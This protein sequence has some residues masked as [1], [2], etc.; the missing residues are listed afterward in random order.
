MK[1]FQEGNEIVER[2]LSESISRT[3]FPFVTNCVVA[4]FSQQNSLEFPKEFV[5]SV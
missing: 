3:G 4:V 2:T 1:T 5:F